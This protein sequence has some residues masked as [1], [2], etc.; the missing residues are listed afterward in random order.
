MRL[1]TTQGK[2][3]RRD[4][5][6]LGV[7]KKRCTEIVASFPVT[8]NRVD[9]PC[10]PLPYDRIPGGRARSLVSHESLQPLAKIGMHKFK[11]AQTHLT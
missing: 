9:V 7:K 11:K 8:V 10:G 2:N 1:S 4:S 5:Q 3:S 6:P